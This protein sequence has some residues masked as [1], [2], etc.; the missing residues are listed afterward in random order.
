MNFSHECERER[1]RE[2]ER[3]RTNLKRNSE[4]TEKETPSLPLFSSQIIQDTF[5]FTPQ[6][7][8]D[9]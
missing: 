3:K 4:K 8:T 6:T 5:P 2:R 7:Y 9:P 1:E